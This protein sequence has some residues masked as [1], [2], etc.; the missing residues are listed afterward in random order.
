MW[1]HIPSSQE[2][3]AERQRWLSNTYREEEHRTFPM[4]VS[5]H[6]LL[7]LV[8]IE[9]AF[10]AGAWLSVIVLSFASVEATLRQVKTVDHSSPAI[11]LAGNDPDLTWLRTIRNEILHS[12]EP[13]T[14][15]LMWKLPSDE[16]PACQASLEAEAKRAVRLAFKVIF[17]NT[18]CPTGTEFCTSTR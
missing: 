7:M 1:S 12:K 6:A 17:A 3:E 5:S 18:T 2:H 15:S 14:T 9:F 11:E 10:R 13:G 4:T 16:I 8:D